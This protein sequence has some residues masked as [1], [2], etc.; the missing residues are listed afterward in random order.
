MQAVSFFSVSPPGDS[1]SKGV[2]LLWEAA[3]RHFVPAV[4]ENHPGDEIVPHIALFL[5]ITLSSEELVMELMK[6]MLE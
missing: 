1:H 3:T 2:Q 4:T 5:V 6:L